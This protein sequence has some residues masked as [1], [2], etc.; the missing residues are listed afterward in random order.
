MVAW[1]MWVCS[2]LARHFSN[3]ALLSCVA[4]PIGLQLGILLG[5][6]VFKYVFRFGFV[7]FPVPVSF[8]PAVFLTLE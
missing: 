3:L 7:R 4:L 1:C 2:A 8:P 6:V 5:N